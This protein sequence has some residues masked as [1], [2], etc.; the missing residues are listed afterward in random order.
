M[1]QNTVRRYRGN[2]MDRWDWKDY[3]AEDGFQ[4]LSPDAAVFALCA[5]AFLALIFMP[6]LSG[7]CR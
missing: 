1:P 5:I 7:S 4:L 2:N 3:R 6:E